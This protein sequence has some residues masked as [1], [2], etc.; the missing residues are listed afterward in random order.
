VYLCSTEFSKKTAIQ[1][2]TGS[3][4]L[5]HTPENT[6]AVYISAPSQFV[7][8]ARDQSVGRDRADTINENTCKQPTFKHNRQEKTA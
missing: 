2:F 4:Q 3:L 6:D 5:K 8:P 1:D 7:H